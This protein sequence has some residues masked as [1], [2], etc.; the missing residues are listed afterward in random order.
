MSLTNDFILSPSLLSSDFSRLAEELAAL[1]SAGLSW[2]HWD[3][4]DGRFVPNITFG[5]PV[6]KACRKESS[7]FFDV[8][9]MIEEP[10]RFIGEFV[11]AGADLICV[12]AEAETHLERT[13]SLIA[14][15][16]VKAAVSLNPH[17]PLETIRYLLPQLS[18]VLIMSVNPGF[19]G[20]S[21]IPFTLD[22]VRDLRAMIDDADT[23]T[24]I[25]MDGGVTLENAPT[26]VAA[27]ADILVSGSAFF[28]HPPYADRHSAFQ[29]AVTR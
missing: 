12:H 16:G 1:E 4:M 25:Q 18:M 3:V 20:Q 26:L 11:D 22:K 10:G 19:G 6:I 9:L 21:F 13:V 5:P 29:Q 27:G 15:S 23:D 17:T 7:L 14:Q 24:R 8:H 2:V 28:G